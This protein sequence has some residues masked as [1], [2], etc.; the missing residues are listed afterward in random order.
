MQHSIPMADDGVSYLILECCSIYQ[1][2]NIQGCSP[3]QAGHSY[4]LSIYDTLHLSILIGIYVY[5]GDFRPAPG[6]KRLVM[7]LIP[8]VKTHFHSQLF[9]FDNDRH[10]SND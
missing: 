4:Q 7:V 9:C 1:K 8:M 6:Q 2:Q 10:T 3:A 5:N